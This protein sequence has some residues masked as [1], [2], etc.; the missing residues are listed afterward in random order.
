[1]TCNLYPRELSNPI[2]REYGKKSRKPLAW[3]GR[4]STVDLDVERL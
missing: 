1:M 2:V 3:E 4:V